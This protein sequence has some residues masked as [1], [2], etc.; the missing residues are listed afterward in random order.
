MVDPV[1]FPILPEVR[2]PASLVVRSL[3]E[4]P[5]MLKWAATGFS[6]LLFLM[7]LQCPLRWMWRGFCVSPTYCFFA[8]FALNKIDDV[9]I[10]GLAGG[11]SLYMEGL[12]SGGANKRV[13]STNVLASEATS[14]AT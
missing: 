3:R 7:S 10:A 2:V 6:V 8:S 12:A 14:V 1:A 5:R 9:D 11:C 4:C 13:P